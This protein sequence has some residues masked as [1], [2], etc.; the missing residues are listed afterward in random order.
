MRRRAGYSTPAAEERRRAAR[1]RQASSWSTPV[2]RQVSRGYEGKARRRSAG[3]RVFRA[4]AWAWRAGE[5]GAGRAAGGRRAGRRQPTVRAG[6]ATA[7][8]TGLPTQEAAVCTRRRTTHHSAASSLPLVRQGG[9]I[10]SIAT[11]IATPIEPPFDTGVSVM[12]L[13]ARNDVADLETLVDL[14]DAGTVS[15]DISSSRHWPTSPTS[16]ISAESAG[17]GAR[18]SSSR[19]SRL[20]SRPGWGG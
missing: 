7:P 5:A 18:S 14:V 2:G 8:G 10:V 13:V 4:T 11:P 9:R 3:W 19:E 12:H 1:V 17:P 20:R 16:T 15:V 6:R